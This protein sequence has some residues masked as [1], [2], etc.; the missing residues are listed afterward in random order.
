[1]SLAPYTHVHPLGH[2]NRIITHNP[3]FV[4]TTQF[5]RFIKL[6]P[7]DTH[8]KWAEILDCSTHGVTIRITR[9]KPNI[10]VSGFAYKLGEIRFIPWAKMS[11]SVVP[12]E[13]AKAYSHWSYKSG[14]GCTW[15][16]YVENHGMVG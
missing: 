7:G 11:Y 16:Q 2:V 13:E 10:S 8:K 15:N 12:E 3:L 5:G 14:D 6:Y 9:I 4:A 1:M